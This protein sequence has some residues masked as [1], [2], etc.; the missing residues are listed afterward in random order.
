[1]HW[2]ISLTLLLTLSG[3]YSLQQAYWFNNAYNSRVG[4]D[5]VIDAARVKGQKDLYSKL[6]LS[7]DILS[8]ARAQGLNTGGAYQHFIPEESAEVSYLVQAAYAD[9][10]VS[11]TWWFPLVGRVP[12]LGYFNRE[13]RNEQA[14]ALRAQGFDVS[15][16]SVGAFSSLGWFDDPIYAS[17]T[18]RSDPEFV[19]LLLHELVHRTYW[20]QGSVTFNENLAEFGSFHLAERFLKGRGDI[21]GQK[22]LEDERNDQ[23]LLRLWIQGMKE[24]LQ[25]IFEDSSLNN[26]RKLVLKTEIIQRYKN[27]KFPSMVTTIYAAARDREWN[28]ASILG[29]SLYSPD[30]AKF[31]RAF[32]CSKAADMG[33]FLKAIKQA[34][35]HHSSAD[36]ALSSL[37]GHEGKTEHGR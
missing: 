37:C 36:D 11:L 20:S 5:G 15:L 21:V 12:Y 31:A 17:M 33:Q 27:E 35:S 4:I 1:M 10:L 34:E 18:K 2:L 23:E 26:E 19:Q 6:S 8:F 29:A 30:T 7:R 9:R 13:K 25:K 22:S 16:G 28:N 32:D 14:Q 3:C 24:D